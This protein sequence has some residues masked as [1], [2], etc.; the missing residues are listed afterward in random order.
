MNEF[1]TTQ[2]LDSFNVLLIGDCCIDEYQIGTV[3]RLSP[4]APV[5]VVNIQEIFSLPGMTSNVS[6]NFKA[7]GID[8]DVITNDIETIV[9]TRIIDKRSGQHLIRVD[10]D[11]NLT[12]WSGNTPFP[13]DHYHAVVISD[14]NKGFL[15]YESIEHIVHS[16]KCPV[17]I[18]TKK[19][20]VSRFSAKNSFIKINELEYKLID[21]APLNLI[22]TLGERGAMLK[23]QRIETVFATKAV[24]VMDVCGCGDT[25]LAALTTQYLLTKNINEAIVFANRASGLTVRHRGN[26]SPTYQEIINA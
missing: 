19:K 17:F 2:L 22:V 18:D 9:K 13:L 1:Q 12:P 15:T 16:A 5:P 24:E 23:T 21:Q 25:F 8:P 26:Y 6:T 14:Y 20:Q 11:Q 7:L 3:D 10:K 4:E